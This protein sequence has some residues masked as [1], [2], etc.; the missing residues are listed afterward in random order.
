MK[1]SVIGILLAVL[2]AFTATG[3]DAKKNQNGGGGGS[4][5]LRIWTAPSYVKVL[6]DIDYSRDDSYASY[7]SRNRL[8]IS[9]YRNEY[10]A[11]QII[12]TTPTDISSYTLELSDLV[13]SSG[14]KLSKE[15]I[16]L[17]NQKYV[18]VTVPS[19][20]HTN[21][22][23]GLQPD[24]M[25]P[26]ETAVKFGE[27]RVFGGLNQSV[28]VE[29]HTSKDQPA[30]VYE[31]SF[32]LNTDGKSHTVPVKVTVF[33]SVVSQT[34]HTKTSFLMTTTRLAKA[35]LDSS[36]EMYERYYDA[37]LD[38]RVC[39]TTMP[40]HNTKDLDE[41]IPQL[42]KYHNNPLASTIDFF[43]CSNSTWTD[44][45][46][47]VFYSALKTIAEESF[48]DGKNYLEKTVYYLSM[49]D[50]PH[51]TGTQAK[52]APIYKKFAKKRHVLIRELN[53][54]KAAYQSE[55]D[56]SD[57]IFDAVLDKIENFVFILTASYNARYIYE[58]NK[59]TPEDSDEKYLITW[60]PTFDGANTSASRAQN[61]SEGLEAWWYG[62]N[63]PV[64]PYVTYHIDDTLLPSRILSWMQYNY[65]IVG[66]LYWAVNDLQDYNDYK[67]KETPEDIY[68]DIANDAYLANGEGFLLYPGK[69]YGL[70]CFVPSIR[71]MAIRDGME[72]YEILKRT[73]ET[74]T[75]IATTA[76]Y[77][78]YNLENTFSKLYD[79]LYQGSRVM[80]NH[81]DFETSLDLLS[82][83]AVFADNGTII[84]SVTN[85]S[86]STEVGIYVSDGVLKVNGVEPAYTSRGSGK[87]YVV[88]VVQS[89]D[90]NYLVFDLEKE[91]KTLNFRMFVGG[92]KEAVDF[93]KITFTGSTINDLTAT[94][95]NDGT[96]T[97]TVGELKGSFEDTRQRVYLTGN[98]VK[99]IFKS[100]IKAVVI[101][102]ENQEDVDL[103]V[104]L[105][106][107]G[108]RNSTVRDA[109]SDTV[110]AGEK[111]VI[112]FE[113]GTLDWT[114]F[115]AMNE[116]RLYLDYGD[117]GVQGRQLAFS[118][119]L[120]Y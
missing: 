16:T 41:Y 26:F 67:V 79:A 87:E 36:Y 38:Y 27:N 69:V 97:V 28:W 106:Y 6:A 8:E 9:M 7:Y 21:S 72:D 43:N 103:E 105:K 45:D 30:G 42:K 83:F 54:G 102:L 95:N 58:N 80:G 13:S 52:V 14:D 90:E 101:E 47:D 82:N 65:D 53:A 18:N 35:E 10:E 73:G 114:L 61:H 117:N 104:S 37:L 71:L 76:G 34:T 23:L 22:V 116:F 5:D 92:K 24:A 110:L 84:T 20:S 11:G 93:N 62:C 74:C 19:P 112:T 29:V 12:I 57:E 44:Y 33:D 66:N 115:G 25:L 68:S 63:W 81:L 111:K 60:C 98:N 2:L 86:S 78:D 85:Q 107:V 100:G 64:N 1:R 120:T 4:S 96:V 109:I 89:A 3:C 59:S 56:V 119:T 113:T 39:V 49:I 75:A 118:I 48:K 55:Y 15:D 88:N 46:Y 40:L 31:G 32:V 70:D 50:E 91:S 51:I 94:K 108:T 99:E 17:Y 77:G